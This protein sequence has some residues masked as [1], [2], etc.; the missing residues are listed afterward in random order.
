[1]S[2][3]FISALAILWCS[4]TYWLGGQELPYYDRGFK[5]IRRYL[6]PLG[7]SIFLIVLH[8]V[9]WKAILACLGLSGATHLGYKDKVWRFAISG[10]LMGA[11]ALILCWPHFNWMVGFPFTYH[12]AYGA[13]S[14]RY[15]RFRW[16]FTGELV[17]IGIG[18]AYVTSATF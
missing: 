3:E 10:L 9:W 12:T 13:I 4:V 14:L 8:A 7:L 1:M 11:P 5:W 18:L 6:M 2:E 15:D 16:A 17:G